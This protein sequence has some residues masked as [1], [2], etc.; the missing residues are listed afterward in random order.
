MKRSMRRNTAL[1]VMLASEL[2]VAALALWFHF[3]ARASILRAFQDYG[4]AMTPYACAALS[5]WLLP[6]ALGLAAL[7]T[8]LGLALPLRGSQQRGLVGAGLFAA[9]AALVFAVVAAFGAIFQPG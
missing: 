3:G 6:G 9:S 7:C 8:A 4:T 1:H 2:G 5:P